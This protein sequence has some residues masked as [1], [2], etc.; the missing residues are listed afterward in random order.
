MNNYIMHHALS[1]VKLPHVTY[2]ADMIC[3]KVYELLMVRV[4]FGYNVTKH[5]HLYIEF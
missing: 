1:D 4:Q 3:H 5:Y 2:Y